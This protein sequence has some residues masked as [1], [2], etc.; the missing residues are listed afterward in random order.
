M[1][2]VAGLRTGNA[3]RPP[4]PVSVAPPARLRLRLVGAMDATA[5]D[6]LS[7]LPRTRKSRALLAIL[8]VLAP[9]KVAR[10]TIA[11]LLWSRRGREQARGS[12]RQALLDLHGALLSG[13]IDWLQ[14][15][16]EHL[17]LPA[18]LLDTD[19]PAVGDPAST[20]LLEDLRGLDPAFDLWI[21]DR[22]AALSGRLPVML[23]LPPGAFP[24]RAAAGAQGRAEGHAEG[25]AEACAAASAAAIP[26]AIAAGIAWA[27]DGLAL[28]LRAGLGATGTGR[29]RLGVMAL[30]SA[31]SEGVS[32]LGRGM[33]G[34][35]TS[36]LSRFGWMVLPSI[37]DLSAAPG[38]RREDARTLGIDFLLDGTLQVA[39]PRLRLHLG[40]HD[41]RNGELAW[42]HSFDRP[43]CDLLDVQGEIAAETVGRLDAA[44]LLREGRRLGRR[45]PAGLTPDECVLAALPAICSLEPSAFAASGAWL[46]AAVRRAPDHAAAHAWL[47]LWQSLR[48]GQGWADNVADAAAEAIR[49]CGRAIM[50]DPADARVL[51]IAGHVRAAVER[52]P[53]EGIALHQRALALNGKLGWA[54]M[55]AG[56]A[57]AYAGRHAEAIGM[58]AE[59]KRLSPSD[60]YGLLFD[61]ALALPHLLSGDHARAIALG[62]QA[63]ALNPALSAT[64]LALLAALGH[65]GSAKE[66]ASARRA[67]LEVD[68]AITVSGAMRRLPLQAPA[69]RSHFAGGLRRA[70]LAD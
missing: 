40:L 48:L 26:S 49:L 56:L 17:A 3:F 12:L 7:V 50:L 42:A 28:G 11:N 29:P 16:R 39:G 19:L 47:G 35:I 5:G 32:W 63:L 58:M 46:R 13:G 20:R 34:E 36:A 55:F 9:E 37:L 45:D 23:A 25:H 21:A 69:D 67:L 54:W 68:P 22:I 15:T 62:R 64:G 41:V 52:R 27:E 70:G 31:D 8:A 57:H 43:A 4:V 30:R 14:A 61:T 60:P 1:S 38:L 59:A 53:E 51:T 18:E 44:L 10:V 65:A 6:G 66:Q 24:P 2:G 33:A